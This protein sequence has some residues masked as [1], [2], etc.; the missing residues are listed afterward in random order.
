MKTREQYEAFLREYEALVRWHG[1]YVDMKDYDG[2]DLHEING[3]D[4]ETGVHMALYQ[5]EP[6]KDE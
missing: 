6:P 2:I 3:D 4:V 5:L 1:I